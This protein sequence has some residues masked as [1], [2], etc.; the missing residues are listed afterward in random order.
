MKATAKATKEKD[1][2]LRRERSLEEGDRKRVS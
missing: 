1:F 2:M